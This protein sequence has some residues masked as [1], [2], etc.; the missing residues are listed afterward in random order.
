MFGTVFRILDEKNRIVLPPAFRDELDGDFYISA[1]LDKILEIR[2]QA[3]FDI[4]AQKIGKA[5][6][7]DPRLR[8]FARYFFGNTVKVSVDKQGRF[9]I[10]K[11][12][13]DLAAVKKRIYL[14]G[15]N[16]K[17]EIWPEERY[18]QFFAKFSDSNVTADLEKELL[19]SGVEL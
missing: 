8:D 18:D 2:S 6:S 4:I 13:L 14:L 19:K 5:N 3:E 17:I 10:P 7:L 16:N 11:N 12:L 9:L 1:N 15:V